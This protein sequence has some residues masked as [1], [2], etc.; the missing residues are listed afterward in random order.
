MKIALRN[1]LS[2]I[3][4]D[5]IVIGPLSS[6]MQVATGE[7]K[8]VLCTLRMSIFIQMI[9]VYDP[10][11]IYAYHIQSA[12]D[13]HFSPHVPQYNQLKLVAEGKNSRSTNSLK[14]MCFTILHNTSPLITAGMNVLM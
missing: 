10:P 13:E 6:D 5:Y 7:Y 2:F 14:G 3:G 4:T 8:I 11:L 1:Q 9:I 12:S